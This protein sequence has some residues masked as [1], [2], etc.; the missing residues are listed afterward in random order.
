MSSF[1]KQGLT[2]CCL[3]SKYMFCYIWW[4]FLDRWLNLPE[5]RDE[6]FV[7]NCKFSQDAPGNIALWCPQVT[8]NTTELLWRTLWIH[9]SCEKQS[10]R[11]SGLDFSF[12]SVKMKSNFTLMVAV[13][14]LHRCMNTE[15][16]AFAS[17][18]VQSDLSLWRQSLQPQSFSR[19]HCFCSQASTLSF[20]L[21]FSS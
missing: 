1:H 19:H 5:K 17:F 11:G 10:E 12:L 8:V 6:C 2:C 18:Q 16:T 20:C 3:L 13:V 9:D 4:R 7:S 15:E 21:C 14:V